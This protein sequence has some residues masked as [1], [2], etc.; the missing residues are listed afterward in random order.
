MKTIEK[1]SYPRKTLNSRARVAVFSQALNLLEGG[2]ALVRD[3]SLSGVWISDLDLPSQ[4]LPTAPFEVAL[5]VEEGPL[6]GLQTS[7]SVARFS[8]NGKLSWGM[9]FEKLPEKY[10][11]ILKGFV[12]Q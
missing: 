8:S 9:R 7:C 10:R 4:S 11:F 1:R 5:I 2:H 12:G 6:K 3:I